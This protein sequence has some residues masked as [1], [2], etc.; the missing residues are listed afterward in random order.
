[1]TYRYVLLKHFQKVNK[2]LKFIN[3]YEEFIN[4]LLLDNKCRNNC[5]CVELHKSI[6]KNGKYHRGGIICVEKL[7]LCFQ[8]N[9]LPDIDELINDYNRL[10]KM[11]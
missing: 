9:N 2:D 3:D 11:D 10:V 1:M 8:D 6:I 4:N 5:G 7:R